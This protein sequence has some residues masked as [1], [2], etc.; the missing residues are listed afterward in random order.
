VTSSLHPVPK[1]PRKTSPLLDVLMLER[2][3]KARGP[4]AGQ[5][6]PR[7]IAGL[8]SLQSEAQF[9]EAVIEFARLHG[10]LVHAER[11]ARSDKGWRTP[12]Q[13]DAG[14]PDL[15]LARGSVTLV[16][17]LKSEKGKR[18]PEQEKWWKA[19]DSCTLVRPRDWPWIEEMLA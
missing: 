7:Q 6:G 12:V 1:R 14:F 9:Q 3:Q 5:A 16:W 8:A 2:K 18:S 11:P 13:G 17:E 19:L 10:W 4:S 15:V